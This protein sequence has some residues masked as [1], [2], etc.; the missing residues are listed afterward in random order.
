MLFSSCSPTRLAWPAQLQHLAAPAGPLCTEAE[1]LLLQTHQLLCSSWLLLLLLSPALPSGAQ[2]PLSPRTS[3]SVTSL[4]LSPAHK[5]GQGSSTHWTVSAVLSLHA[6]LRVNEGLTLPWAALAE[7]SAPQAHVTTAPTSPL[8]C[9]SRDSDGLFH[10]PVALYPFLLPLQQ[11]REGHTQLPSTAT[12]PCLFC[13]SHQGWAWHNHLSSGSPRHVCNLHSAL[14][15]LW[16]S[17][18]VQKGCPTAARMSQPP[19][20]LLPQSLLS[21]DGPAENL[22]FVVTELK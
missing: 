22:P 18:M 15:L 3:C 9:W 10:C 14:Q 13:P 16:P 17:R 19:A 1:A 21:R 6:V 11:F 20:G 12:R 8:R 4:S 7:L 2:L 5:S